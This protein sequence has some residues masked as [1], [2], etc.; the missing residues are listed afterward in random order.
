[1]RCIALA[2]LFHVAHRNAVSDTPKNKKARFKMKRAPFVTP[3]GLFHEPLALI[4]NKH[5]ARQ[6]DALP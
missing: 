2:F 3:E 4:S 1:M 6:C 5:S